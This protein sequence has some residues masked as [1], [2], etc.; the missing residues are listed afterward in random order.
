M[1]RED[2]VELVGRDR[3]ETECAIARSDASR[4]DYGRGAG[5][6]LTI[7]HEIDEALWDGA[8]SWSEK[9]SHFFEIYD[10]MPAYT[11]LM[12]VQS[13]F[14]DFDPEARSAW[15]N[16]IRARLNGLDSALRGPLLYSLW[17]DFFE[18]DVLVSEAWAALT[19]SDATETSLRAVLP[20]SGPVPF[21]LKQELYRHLIDDASWH[22]PIFESLLGSA[23]D[24]LGKIDR[25]SAGRILRKLRLPSD[26]PGL[27][28]LRAK[29]A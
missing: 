22:I 25:D 15:W 16:E 18:D 26:L 28:D 6:S 5:A 11:H 21:D 4:A 9:V 23:F 13:R 27:D 20:I 12:Y 14:R 8:G 24:V 7:P 29:L 1:T 3:Y 19:G 2:I 17:C 10:E